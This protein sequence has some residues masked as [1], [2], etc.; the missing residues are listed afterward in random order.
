MKN[1]REFAKVPGVKATFGHSYALDYFVRDTFRAASALESGDR[2]D[3]EVALRKW[4]TI[5]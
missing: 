1:M 4:I 5:Q 3:C 2:D